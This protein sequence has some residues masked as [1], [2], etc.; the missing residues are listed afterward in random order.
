LRE[1]EDDDNQENEGSPNQEIT[2]SIDQ[3]RNSFDD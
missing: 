3:E 2:I 1:L